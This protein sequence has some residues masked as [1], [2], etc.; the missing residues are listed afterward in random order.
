MRPA[1]T[2]LNEKEN[3]LANV[4]VPLEKAFK[5]IRKVTNMDMVN[6]RDRLDS[7][8]VYMYSRHDVIRFYV[9]KQL[10]KQFFIV[11]FL[12]FCEAESTKLSFSLTLTINWP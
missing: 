1:N 11:P 4:N 9:N 6:F 5:L 3:R 2:N 10:T 12:F 7:L 8:Y